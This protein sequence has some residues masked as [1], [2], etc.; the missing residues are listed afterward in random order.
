MPNRRSESRW[1]VGVV[2]GSDVIASGAASSGGP[3]RASIAGSSAT[4]AGPPHCVVYTYAAS[5]VRVGVRV[6]CRAR[7]RVGRAA[8][9]VR[10]GYG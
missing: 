7:A 6:E 4:T 5:F 2:G 9:D 8:C 3:V 10:A 1:I